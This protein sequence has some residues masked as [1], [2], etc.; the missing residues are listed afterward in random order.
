[1]K[2][3]SN[4]GNRPAFRKTKTELVFD[5]DK[6]TEFLTG[7]Q[8]RKQHRKKIAKS[9]IE[10]KLKED[11]RRM[12]SD[13]K[14]NMKKLYH[15]YKPIPELTADDLDE[16]QEYDTENVT[17]KV[18][19]LSTTD[20]AKQ[21]NWIGEN[22]A[23]VRDE[24]ESNEEPS[25]GDE[26][27][28]METIPGM[29]LDNNSHRKKSKVTQHAHEDGETQEKQAGTSP[30]QKP[31]V[32]VLNLDGIRSKKELNHK[33][34]RYALKSMQKSKAF[35]LSMRAK[36]QKQLKKSRRDRHFKDKI[37]KRKGK[38]AAGASGKGKKREKRRD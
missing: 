27:D 21:N 32:P 36:Q 18:V 34:K 6:R 16:E 23:A 38:L 10:R 4:D 8:K 31:R 15:S 5:P 33:L 11:T 19:E 25:S 20:L 24:E 13:A 29:E 2:R 1:M 9:E 22:R 12:R 3:K 30:K 14:E 26:E 28:D 17:V 35:Q 37:L 7:F